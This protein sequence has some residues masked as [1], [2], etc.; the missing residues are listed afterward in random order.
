[1]DERLLKKKPRRDASSEEISVQLI[2]IPACGI[3]A[4]EHFIRSRFGTFLQHHFADLFTKPSQQ[5]FLLLAFGFV[6][7]PTRHTVANYI[8]RAGA[9]AFR[10]FT[11]F[12]VFLGGPFYAQLDWLWI[13]VIKLAERHVPVGEPVRLRFDETTC[14]KTGPTIEP[15]DYYRNGAGSARQEYRTLYGVN[16]VVGEMLIRLAPW[17]EAFVSLPIGIEVYLKEEKARELGLAYQRRSELARR[18]L[19]RVAGV[20]SPHRRILSVQ[21]GGYATRYFLRGLPENVEVVGRLPKN[22]PLYGRPAPKPKGRPG[23]QPK[24]GDRLGTPLDFAQGEAAQRSSWQPH[25]S[26]HRAEVRLVHGIWQSVLPGRM[27]AVVLVRRCHLRE[28]PSKRKRQRWLEVFFTTDLSLSLEE[29]LAEYRARWS[30][31]ILLHEARESYGLGK[32]RCRSYRKIVGINSFRLLLGAA[33]VLH[34]AHAVEETEAMDLRRYRS[35][36][37]TKQGPSL[38]D[39]RWAVREHLYQE[40]IYPKVGFW[41]TMAV[42]DE[43]SSGGLPRAA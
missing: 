26:E 20:V 6:L 1:L 2:L 8:W 42:F 36:Y 41:E 39:I 25:P 38:F 35:W 11:R 19:D 13:S 43:G 33:E 27:L 3:I 14:K 40:G 5:V 15:A 18:M 17:P 4:V 31:E 21:D 37:R 23:P 12:Y 34:V 24:I 10:H 7:S 28:H 30:I 32:D 29:I 9:T 16:F 22:S